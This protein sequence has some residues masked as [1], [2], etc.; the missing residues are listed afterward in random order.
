MLSELY[1]IYLVND[2]DQSDHRNGWVAISSV[3]TSA[4][5]KVVRKDEQKNHSRIKAFFSKRSAY[6][7][8][9]DVERCIQ[10]FYQDRTLSVQVCTKFLDV[11]PQI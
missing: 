3:L 11:A 9:Q 4:A 2:N 1:V 10:Q 5:L 6:Q 8:A 7:Y